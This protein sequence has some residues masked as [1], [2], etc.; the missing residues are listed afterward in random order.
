[1]PRFNAELES[2]EQV[3]RGIQLGSDLTTLGN[4]LQTENIQA[5]LPAPP[6]D[7]SDLPVLTSDCAQCGV[8][9]TRPGPS[10]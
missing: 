1:M 4:D 10:S 9:V 7:P 5:L 8:T 2:D 3:A 6:G